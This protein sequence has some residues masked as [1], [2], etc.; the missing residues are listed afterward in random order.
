MWNIL[1][2]G[3]G[4]P[5][6]CL[7]SWF[8]VM[9]TIFSFCNLKTIA[10][11]GPNKLQWPPDCFKNEQFTF[12]VDK[13]Q[14]FACLLYCLNSD[15]SDESK[16]TIP[17][18]IKHNGDNLEVVD[19]EHEFSNRHP[20]PERVKIVEIKNGVRKWSPTALG[21]FCNL[22]KL[23]IPKSVRIKDGTMFSGLPKNIA[24][25]LNRKDYKYENDT[26][27]DAKKRILIWCNIYGNKYVA[28][29][30]LEVI[31]RNAFCSSEVNCVDLTK[32]KNLKSIGPY[33]FA[34]KEIKR[35]SIPA[36]VQ[37]IGNGAFFGCPLE[38]V[39]FLK[40]N[41]KLIIGYDAFFEESGKN[42]QIKVPKGTSELFKNK[43]KVSGIWDRKSAKAWR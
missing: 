10:A 37:K 36:S 29:S 35:I 2:D 1:K 18:T 6:K 24:I 26:L 16:V 7:A 28:P 8:C 4:N 9:L 43:L 15:K 12:L 11:I 41:P 32:T 20:S 5:K 17:A 33:A 40:Y 30:S 38:S 22:E 14:K 31:S 42:P 3:Y 21:A 39:T 23:H 13:T 34:G 25:K 19:I 27:Y